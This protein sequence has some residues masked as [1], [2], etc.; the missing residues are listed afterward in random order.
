MGHWQNMPLSPTSRGVR[1]GPNL[2]ENDVVKVVL[3]D[4]SYKFQGVGGK[5]TFKTFPLTFLDF[6]LKEQWLNFLTVYLV[7]ETLELSNIL[8]CKSS[9][10]EQFCFSEYVYKCWTSVFFNF[11]QNSIRFIQ[12]SCTAVPRQKTSTEVDINERICSGRQAT[13]MF[14]LSWR[15]SIHSSSTFPLK[16][17]FSTCSST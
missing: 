3:N 5:K 12:A 1:A 7:H 11:S 4:P 10:L 15:V 13:S 8:Y 16:L 6:N 9:V 17:H 14:H 2:W